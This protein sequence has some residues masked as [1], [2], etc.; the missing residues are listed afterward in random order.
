M[1]R[2]GPD[3][4]SADEH[5]L[6]ARYFQPL[7]GTSAALGL[8]DDAA[9]I[10]PPAGC[11]L[12]ATKDGIA[13]GVHF[14]VGETGAAVARK[15]LRVNLSDIA[16]MGADPLGYLVLLCLPEAWT[17]DWLADF[18]AGLAADQETYGLSLYGGDSI[19]AAGLT[20]G[21]TMLGT[22]PAGRAVR[23]SGAAP[24]DIIHVSGTI[25][26][27]ALGL[28]AAL[29]GLGDLDAAHRQYLA[30]RYRQPEPRCGLAGVLR[31]EA[32]AA[33]D[34]S[35][36]LAGDLDKLCGASGVSARIRMDQM[37]LSAA[38]RA[39]IAGD[40][41]RVETCITGGDDYEILCAVP[42]DRRERFAA[43]AEAAGVPVTAIGEVV[44]GT[45][46]ATFVDAAGEVRSFSR[47]SFSHTG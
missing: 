28:K 41:A 19:R 10:A 22:V 34:I 46:P 16:A 47:R 15:A 2:Q 11:D 35:D 9:A 27:G 31:T 36:G 4:G 20:I 7:A 13:E 43:G 42:P 8:L 38:A 21:I 40:G 12:I 37:P 1:T 26:D 44:A 30:E 18:A 33:I 45:G 5:E 29:G 14:P 39:A 17:E 6:I 25:G 32:S 23:R 24:G 3:L